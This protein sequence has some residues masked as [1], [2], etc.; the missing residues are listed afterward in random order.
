MPTLN[1]NTYFEKKTH[2]SRIFYKL[3]K[4]TSNLALGKKT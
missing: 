3:I 2:C 4:I 1:N